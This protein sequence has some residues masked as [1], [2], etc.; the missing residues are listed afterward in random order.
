VYE[1][2]PLFTADTFEGR[3]VME[4]SVNE[5]TGGMAGG[6][7]NDEPRGFVQNEENVV[8]EEDV[9][10]DGFGFERGGSGGRDGEEYTETGREAKAG[11]GFSILDRN[12][13]FLEQGLDSGAGEIRMATGKPEIEPL[14]R[15]F[16]RDDQFFGHARI[17]KDGGTQGRR[18]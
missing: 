3:A 16:R 14:T 17:G 2:W 7:V 5:G 11:F 8:L 12:V 9:K 4:E 6:W 15:G 10:G 18:R 1:T 13:S